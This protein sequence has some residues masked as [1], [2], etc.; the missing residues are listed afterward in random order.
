[1]S[2]LAKAAQAIDVLV[3]SPQPQKLGLLADD[4]RIPKSSAHRVLAE[5]VELGLARRLSDGQYAAGH[6]LVQWGR[7]AEEAI[8]LRAIAE[9]VMR[10]LMLEVNESVHLHVLDGAQ[11]VCVAAVDSTHTLRPVIRLGQVLGLGRGA[12][13]KLLLAFV[14]ESTLRRAEEMASPEE[15]SLWPDATALEQIRA[16]GW[17]TSIAE[18]ESGL[19]AISAVVPTRTKQ[20]LGGLS[21]AGA[22]FRLSEE[23]LREIRPALVAAASEIAQSLNA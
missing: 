21:V 4:L 9:P 14:D 2:V 23:R 7:A 3:T 12:A 19:T 10:R 6:R 8:G 5:L 1:M 22:T 16:Q 18:M 11:R 17:A 20:A 15:R 13:G